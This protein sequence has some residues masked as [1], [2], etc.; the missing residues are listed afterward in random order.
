MEAEFE[1]VGQQAQR[2]FLSMLAIDAL[3]A[4]M[5][6]VEKLTDMAVDQSGSV[7]SPLVGAPGSG[8]CCRRLVQNRR[9]AACLPASPARW[10][11][12]PTTLLLAVCA[13]PFLPVPLPVRAQW[14]VWTW[15]W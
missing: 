12:L 9:E 4:F 15:R 6:S 14:T 1:A 5:G 7:P 2:G 13:H 3:L 10:A 11:G 8:G